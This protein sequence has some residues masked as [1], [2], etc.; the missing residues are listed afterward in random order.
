MATG[1]QSPPDVSEPIPSWVGTP[2]GGNAGRSASAIPDS[3]PASLRE[4]AA[5]VGT[6]AVFDLWVYRSHGFAGY[7]AFY[8]AAAVLLLLGTTKP[9]PRVGSLVIGLLLIALAARMVWLGYEFLHV[10]GVALLVALTVSFAGRRAFVLDVI[11]HGVQALIA[12]FPALAAMRHSGG[13]IGTVRPTLAWLAVVLPLVGVLGFGTIFILANPDV[14]SFVGERIRY[15]WNATF[16]W[17]AHFSPEFGEVFAWFFVALGAAGLLRPLVRT[18]LLAWLATPSV[19]TFDEDEPLTD[20]P[21]YAACRNTLVALIGLFTI[22][23]VFEFKTLWFKTFPQGFYY[24]GY[25]HEGAA[26][27]TVALA[28]TTL[29]LSAIFRGGMLRDPRVDRLKR[30]AWVW[31]ALNLLLALA[32]YHRMQIYIDFN[33]MTR[34]RTIGLFGITAVVIGFLLCVWKIVRDRDFA[35]LIERQLWTVSIAGVLL[36]ILPIDP[37]IHTYNVRRVL[38]GDLAPSVQ[39]TEHDVDAGGVLVLQPL[40]RSDNETIREGIRALLAERALRLEA[41]RPQ[42]RR[43]GWTAYQAADEQLRKD[44]LA[45]RDQWSTYTDDDARTAAWARFKSYAY[46]WY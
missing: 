40:L 32:V 29:V 23:L 13:R 27:L 37:L 33:G 42:R 39:I 19:A 22:Y 12:G 4:L 45:R 11:A 21:L 5:I 18:H 20:A 31:S 17:I 9:R 41:E 36:V 6:I 8:V 43:L 44:L 7:A 34:M 30:L 1:L 35:W 24:A 14:A 15:G 26:W 2:P 25:A 28:L 16:D 46:Q 10:V 38:A 3:P